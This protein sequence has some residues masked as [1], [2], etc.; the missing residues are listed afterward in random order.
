MLVLLILLLSLGLIEG[1]SGLLGL[2]MKEEL[3]SDFIQLGS[4]FAR[5]MLV[6]CYVKKI[7]VFV[8][9]LILLAQ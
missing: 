5:L 4:I 6:L 3:T 8:W 1:I 2:L 9:V 7:I